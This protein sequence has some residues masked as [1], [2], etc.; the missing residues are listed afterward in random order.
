MGSVDNYSKCSRVRTIGPSVIKVMVHAPLA[1]Q[2]CF[3]ADFDGLG[4]YIFFLLLLK[5]T[6]V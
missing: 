6:D 1:R 3:T 4:I 5:C 2:L